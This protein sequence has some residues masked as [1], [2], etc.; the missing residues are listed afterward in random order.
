MNFF[1][2]PSSVQLQEMKKKLFMY[3]TTIPFY[4]HL[5][6]AINCISFLHSLG[7]LNCLFFFLLQFFVLPARS[8][9]PQ[10]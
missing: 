5:I 7:K 1:H 9:F 3:E 8:S 6:R 4:G 2:H 10:T